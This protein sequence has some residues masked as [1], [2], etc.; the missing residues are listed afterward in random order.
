MFHWLLRDCP[1]A[2]S[3]H[4]VSECLETIVGIAMKLGTYICVLHFHTI[5]PLGVTQQTATC[6]SL[7]YLDWVGLWSVGRAS[8]F[9][10][11]LSIFSCVLFSVNKPNG[12]LL[13]FV[14]RLLGIDSLWLK[15]RLDWASSKVGPTMYLWPSLWLFLLLQRR[16]CFRPC[17]LVCQQ[18]FA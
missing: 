7:D 12:S 8:S 18:D 14:S 13:D 4:R 10:M 5:V 2:L 15:A 17:P 3:R 11:H 9:E 1:P 6:T 16:L